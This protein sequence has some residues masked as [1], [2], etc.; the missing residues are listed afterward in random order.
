MGNL[1]FNLF[2]LLLIVVLAGGIVQGRKHGI[3]LE[4][5]SALKWV[6][7]VLAC[8]GFYGPAGQMIAGIGEFDLLTCY[9]FSYLG[10][11]LLIF[12]LFSILERRMGPKLAGS[13]IFGRG[14][15]FLG[16]GSGMLR[17][18]CIMLT[19][20]AL[21]NA[22]EF[23][24]AELKNNERYQEENYGSHIFPGVH[25]LQVAVFERSFFGYFIRNDLGFLLINPTGADEKAPKM[26]ARAREAK[27]H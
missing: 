12:L 4:L 25:S 9:L 15:Y 13:D 3:S 5:V 18:A 7:L 20:L 21:L 16:M 19:G 26:E 10:A 27:S 6:T 22:R 14:E 23:T 8:A 24:P 17:F 11:A 1:P 2:D